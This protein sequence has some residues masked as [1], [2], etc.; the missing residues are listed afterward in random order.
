MLDW[1]PGR[2]LV[3]D[4]AAILVAMANAHGG[5]VLLGV[6]P[7]SDKPV[8]VDDAENTRLTSVLEAALVD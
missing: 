1:L 8:G 3:R 4:I 2:A 5:T 7:R 6:A